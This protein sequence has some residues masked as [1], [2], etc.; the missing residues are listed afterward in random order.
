[1]KAADKGISQKETRDYA[2]TQKC[3]RFFCG[4]PCLKIRRSGFL[5]EKTKSFAKKKIK[6][7][8]A[9]QKK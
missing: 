6:V 9:S 5:R 8:K 2:G 7:S 3:R 1:M 4:Y